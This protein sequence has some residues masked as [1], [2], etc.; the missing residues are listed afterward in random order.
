MHVNQRGIVWGRKQKFVKQDIDRL[1]RFQRNAVRFISGDYRSTT[2]GFVTSLLAKHKLPPL[3]D[4]RE[5]LRLL[6]F[7]KVVEGLVPPDQFVIPQKQGRQIRSSQRST[8]SF[9]SNNP[10]EKYIRNNDRCFT[11]PRS[12]TEQYKNSFFPKTIIAWN[13]LDNQTVHSASPECFKSAL[14]KANRR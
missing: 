5:S 1:E 2:P 3:Q 9:L 7:F 14:A 6:F 11:V 8:Q 10:V 4:R 12:N 13:H